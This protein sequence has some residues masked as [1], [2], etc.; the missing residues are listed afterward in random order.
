MNS[1]RWPRA[2][3]PTQAQTGQRTKKTDNL[4]DEIIHIVLAVAATVQKTACTT[5]Q[6]QAMRWLADEL[7]EDDEGNPVKGKGSEGVAKLCVFLVDSW[8]QERREQI[9]RFAADKGVAAPIMCHITT[10][11]PKDDSCEKEVANAWALAKSKNSKWNI[12]LRKGVTDPVM[13]TLSAWCRREMDHLLQEERGALFGFMAQALGLGIVRFRE[14]KIN[15]PRPT[16]SN[17]YHMI[18]LS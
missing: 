14:N 11:P 6:I 12:T 1:W 18:C 5:R 9:W 17:M 2:C 4:C 10:I 16:H 13:E 8:W 3:Q 15:W 7:E